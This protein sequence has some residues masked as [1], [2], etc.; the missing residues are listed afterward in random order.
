M[1][2]AKEKDFSQLNFNE[3][4]SF[5]SELRIRIYL[6]MKKNYPTYN[7]SKISQRYANAADQ[8]RNIDH[9]NSRKAW[10]WVQAYEYYNK[11][12]KFKRFD[13]AISRDSH[14]VGLAYGLPTVS[15]SNLKIDLVEATPIS[16]HK[17]NTKIFDIISTSAQM[18]ASLIGANEVRIIN[19]LNSELVN[20]YESF[21]Y[22]Y[23]KCQHDSHT[24][25]CSLKM[26]N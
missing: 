21:G 20:Y 19:P 13:M 12:S 14:L 17:N 8:W 6:R 1:D 23:V 9:C 18:Y 15:K 3:I 16:E 10:S 7:F 24:T 2:S 5:Y 25:Y 11:K 4:T 26:D 22:N